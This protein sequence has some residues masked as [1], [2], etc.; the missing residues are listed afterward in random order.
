MDAVH[1]A[2]VI[3][4]GPAGLAVG[5]CLA[6]RGMACLM[7][8]QGGAVGTAWRRHYDRLHLHTDKGHSAL[9]FMP[10][11]RHY[12]RYPARQQVID[13]LE[14]YARYFQLQP[15][16]HQQVVAARYSAGAWEVHTSE[17]S[18]RAANLIVAAGYC[19][20][21]CLPEWPA[22]SSFRGTMLHSCAYRTAEAF[23]EQRVL[24]VGLGNSGGEIAVDL[25]Q[26][27][28]QPSLA[29]R[30]AVNVIPREVLG[31]PIL[32]LG[33]AESRLPP[34]IA[35]ALNAVILRAVVGDLARYGL[36]RPPHGPIT[37]IE[38]EARVP[39]IDV[40]TLELIR[41]GAIAV[42][43][44]IARYEEDA[45]I[46]S[47]GKRER[48]DAVILATGYRPRVNAFLEAPAGSCDEHGTPR[49]SGRA[50]APGLYFCGYHVARTGMLREI[51][52]EARSIAAAIAR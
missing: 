1:H 37:Q 52:R 5:A 40:G 6:R 15:G 48:F 32:A 13:Y 7:L 43:P 20:E 39:L 10:F 34:R 50:C 9:P 22:R 11:P 17:R 8:E 46:F 49:S 14:S 36:R 25:H 19:R 35:D 29:V 27:G 41:R 42:R 24:V 26:H 3:G 28:A 44:G 33:I 45:V 12:P 30:G 2:I 16:F 31:I 18:Y 21:P 47:D 51:A 23:R 38:R 4:A